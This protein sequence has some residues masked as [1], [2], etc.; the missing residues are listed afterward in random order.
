MVQELLTNESSSDLP[1][2]IGELIQ[3]L[4]IPEWD[5]GPWWESLP[6]HLITP[7]ESWLYP[8]AERSCPRGLEWSTQRLLSA[9]L[10]SHI[11]DLEQENP[12]I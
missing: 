8:L 2:P 7:W 4:Y 12:N 10:Q 6:Y 9:A 5:K 1:H 11:Q 3:N